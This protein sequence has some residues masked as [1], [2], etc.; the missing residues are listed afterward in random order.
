MSALKR[1]AAPL[2]AGCCTAA[3][4]TARSTA[5]GDT[6]VR[7][8]WLSRS[9]TAPRGEARGGQ[10]RAGHQREGYRSHQPTKADRE[11]HGGALHAV[12]REA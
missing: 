3:L 1:P 7:P 9:S 12:G 2:T 6:V 4:S 10:L 11:P 5:R 8:R